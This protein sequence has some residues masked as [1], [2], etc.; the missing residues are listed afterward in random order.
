M[1]NRPLVLAAV[2]LSLAGAGYAA[3]LRYESE[4]MIRAPWTQVD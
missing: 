3:W 2:F 4:R 1:R